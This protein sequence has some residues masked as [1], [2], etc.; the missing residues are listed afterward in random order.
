MA[1][2]NITPKASRDVH[3]ALFELDMG[4]TNGVDEARTEV[5]MGFSL[6]CIMCLR[7][8]CIHETLP[9]RYSLIIL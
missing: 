8:E 1:S 4:Q 9:Q 3:E 5:R 6:H 2:W 7:E